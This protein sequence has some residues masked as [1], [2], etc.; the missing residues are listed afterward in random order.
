LLTIISEVLK[1]TPE[2]AP[3]VKEAHKWDDF[4]VE[5]DSQ[6]LFSYILAGHMEKSAQIYDIPEH[7]K[8]A[9][10]MAK[11]RNPAITRIVDAIASK[12][13]PRLEASTEEAL[14]KE[15]SAE[16]VE[17]FY[18]EKSASELRDLASHHSY[19]FQTPELAIK[20]GQKLFTKEAALDCLNSRAAASEDVRYAKLAENLEKSAG[21]LDQKRCADLALA[22]DIIDGETGL[23]SYGFN[24][25]KEAAV[26][27][28][29]LPVKLDKHS[30][31]IEELLKH[32]SSLEDI[33][34]EKLPRDPQELK[35]V[36]E[37]LPLDHKRII[38]KHVLRR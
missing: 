18:L 12:Q 13:L 33:V 6:V 25:S 21:D 15:A 28:S 1:Q 8:R 19:E 4:P 14:T 26:R 29:E 34:G 24:F 35:M 17:E 27:R 32:H 37:T 20:A 5:T 7:V 31:P 38:E 2:L 9:V 30:V 36:M 16:L 10:H 11:I 23:S 22:L 3:L